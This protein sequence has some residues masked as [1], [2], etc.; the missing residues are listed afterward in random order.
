MKRKVSLIVVGL[1]SLTLIVT[2]SCN[3]ARK[4]EKDEADLIQQFLNGNSAGVQVKESG[5]YY[6]ETAAG[7]GELPV[8]GDSVFVRYTGSFVGGKVFDSNVDKDPYVFALG[9]RAVI[10]GFDEGISYMKKGGK[11]KILLPSKLGYGVLGAWGIPGYT[12]LVF[13]IELVNVKPMK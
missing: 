10:D 13:D 11:A 3:P 5:L 2:M 7:T 8:A 9:S 12:P 6:W 4:Y 1:V